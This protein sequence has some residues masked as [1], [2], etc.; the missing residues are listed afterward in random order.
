MIQ[1]S[2]PYDPH[3]F[4]VETSIDAELLGTDRPN[5]KTVLAKP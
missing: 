2:Y 3:A 5:K 1:Q 4:L